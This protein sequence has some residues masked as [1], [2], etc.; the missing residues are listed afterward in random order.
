MNTDQP[1]PAAKVPPYLVIHHSADFDGIF[2]REI[3][4]RFLGSENCTFVGW[5][6]G[7]PVP[8][9][10]DAVGTIY[11]L[12]ISIPELMDESRIVWIDHHKSAM[13]KYPAPQRPGL[14][15][16][17]VAACRLA[18][19]YYFKGLMPV[20]MKED[21]IERRVS[22]PLAVRLAGEYDI[23]DRRDPRAELFQHG[24]RSREL[25]PAL[26]DLLLVEPYADVGGKQGVGEIAVDA[27]LEA[28]KVLQYAK[29]ES[30]AAIIK[31]AGFTIEFEGLRFLACNA[32]QFNSHLFEA[33]LTPEH[34][35]CMGFNYD[36][37]RWKVSL[38]HAPGREHIDLSLIAVRYG[39]G[40]HKGA[41]GFEVKRYGG[42]GTRGCSLPFSEI[43][44]DPVFGV[45]E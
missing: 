7:Q 14:R 39:G 8:V 30:N 45:Q 41:C 35:A 9:V 34:D 2:C 18:W 17:G 43:G 29:R 32:S 33:G 31:K 12:D 24:L 10:D 40:G 15:I 19:Q 42:F 5:D 28:G 11:M 25:S 20:A 26:W 1:S 6:Y 22:E 4:R 21:Y 36:G 3:A 27:L 37:V 44:G 16:D 23:W 38:Y 13:E